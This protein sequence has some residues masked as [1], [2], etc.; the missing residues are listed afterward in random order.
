MKKNGRHTIFLPWRCFWLSLLALLLLCNGPSA[1]TQSLPAYRFEYLLIEDGLPQNTINC[2]AQDGY[3]FMWFGTNNGLCRY[4]S[5]EFEVF[6]ADGGGVTLPDNLVRDIAVDERGRVWIGSSRGL[7]FFDPQRHVVVPFADS[8]WKGQPVEGVSSLMVHGNTVWAGTLRSGIF[9]VEFQGQEM[10]VVQHFSEGNGKIPESR[11]N[12]IYRDADGTVYAGG[13]AAAYVL[14]EAEKRFVVPGDERALPP[15]TSVND[16]YGDGEGNLY[17]STRNGLFVVADSVMTYYPPDAEDPLALGHGVVNCVRQDVTGQV[18]V[19]TLGGLYLFLPGEGIFRAFPQEGHEHF[20][21]NSEFVSTLHCDTLGN[22]WI[23]TEAGGINKFNV[24]QHPF[25]HYTH[26]PNDPNSLNVNTVN[27]IYTEQEELWI[28]TA[29]GGLNHVNMKSGRFDHHTFRAGDARSLS[30]N[31]VSAILRGSEHTLWVGTWGGGLNGLTTGGRRPVIERV[32]VD[33]GRYSGS[34]PD[35]F[36]A[37][38]VEDPGG[39]LLIGAEGGLWMLH[40]ATRHFTALQA[41]PEMERELQEIGCVLLDSKG[42]Y[43]IGTRQGLFRFPRSSVRQTRDDTL[44]VSML[45]Y[46]Q[47]EPADDRS[48]PGDYII[49]LLED[50]RGNLWIGTYG[51]GLVKAEV[52]SAGHL[53]CENYT[54]DDGLSNN[55]IYGIVEDRMER[56]WMSTDNGISMLEPD[57]SHFRRFYMHDGLLSNQF[58]WSAAHKSAYGTIFFGGVEGLNYFNPVRFFDYDFRPSPRI[59]HFRIHNREVRPG[60]AFN[61]RVAIDRPV[62]TVDTIR[63]TYQSNNISFEFSSLDYYLPEKSR[64]AYML[65]G[66]DQDWVNVP[67]SRRFANYNYLEGGTYTFLLKASNGDG[68]WSEQPTAVTIIVTPPFWKT[69]WFIALVV[70]F[71]VLLSY[72][73]VRYQ[74]RRIV[75]QKKL[76]EEK[77]QRRTREIEQQKV[78]LEQQAQELMESNAK[79]EQRGEKIEQQKEELETMNEEVSKQRDELMLLN[80]KVNEVNQVQLR[81]FTNISHEFQTP[82]TLITSPVDRLLK[83]FRDNREAVH[84]LQIVDRN[85]QRLLML[86]RQLLE[87]RKIET[88]HQ[89]LQVELTDVKAFIEQI[90]HSFDDLAARNR[91]DYRLDL[92]L[93]RSAWIDKEKL[94]NVLYNLLSNAF[95][96]SDPGATIVL[97]GSIR[98]LDAAEALVLSV[99]DTGEGIPAEKME[100][101]FDRFQQLSTSRKQ[102]RAGAGIGL[103]MARSLVELMHGTIEVESEPGEGTA[104]TI[105]LPVSKSAFEEDEIDT[106]GQVFES[107]IHDRVAVLVDQ[108]DGP[109]PLEHKVY[110]AAVDTVLVVEDN[111]DMRSFICSSLAPWFR[112]IE[113]ENGEEGLAR[114]QKEG[115]AI[116]ISDIM[117]PGMDGIGLCDR[118]KSNLYTSH[119]PVILLTARSGTEDQ[120]KGLQTGAD[121]YVTKPFNV[122]VLTARVKTLISNRDRLREKYGRLEEVAADD[123]G[124]SALDRKF[125]ERAVEIVGKHYSDPAFDVDQFASEMLVSRS[126]LYNKLKAITN[127]SANEFINTYRLK[128]S[129][130]L[131]EQGELQIS[132]VA[133]ETGFNDPKYFSRIFRKYYHMKPSEVGRGVGD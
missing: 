65:T 19:A 70:A 100:K 121:D 78:I 90:F 58:Y 76:L 35:A 2:M 91:M 40:Y 1:Y 83:Q 126:Q 61:N 9:R 66:V 93:G 17:F 127:L 39:F 130:A 129:Y 20:R 14:D 60:V 98:K 6:Q 101:L 46:F 133:Y 16:I 95:K 45:Q 12:V 31:Y 8:L 108:I 115:P 120:V 48:L 122:D 44:V 68:L 32:G 128:R 79:L 87:I 7:S 81:F 29:G 63:L 114:A 82:L 57:S 125:F 94:E 27:S 33:G 86:I 131:L 26:D 111:P 84:L 67:A 11:V 37:A 104:F 85:A 41:P 24:H 69:N 106:T 64:Y 43:W 119:I 75:A 53:V 73:V 25:L 13:D 55:V 51:N 99:S 123:D 56:L 4:D 52:T 113:A 42:Y 124:L 77:V 112:V 5:Y 49:S 22:V 118:L 89:T 107:N 62:Y 102:Q 36:I 23:G 103:S 50:S 10:R 38:M 59:T 110:G 97:A 74:L 132:E 21:L 109:A 72:G 71:I 92:S 30:S 47:H 3:G 15:A 80:E 54:T 116:V 96:F 18:L 105:T 117:M 34:Q 28:G 88:G